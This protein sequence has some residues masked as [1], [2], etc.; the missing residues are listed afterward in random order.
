MVSERQRQ[1]A[2]DKMYEIR[3]LSPAGVQ[4]TALMERR[5]HGA[6]AICGFE[7]EVKSARG[8]LRRLVIDHD[9]ATGLVRDLL[10]S[11]CNAALGLFRDDLEVMRSA[12]EYLA[13]H[14]DEPSGILYHALVEPAA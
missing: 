4:Y 1:I 5:G 11:R 14:R 2:R 8:R 3:K 7:E 9:H 6:C 13:K 10:C 12:V